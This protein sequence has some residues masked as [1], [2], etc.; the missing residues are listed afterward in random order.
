MFLFIAEYYEINGMAIPYRQIGF[1]TL[2]DFLR[3]HPDKFRISQIGG[4]FAISAVLENGG[5]ADL[6]RLV[7]GQKSSKKKKSKAASRPVYST[8]KKPSVYSAYTFKS[9][10]MTQSPSM[11]FNSKLNNHN[12]WWWQNIPFLVEII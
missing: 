5:M 1:D 8:Y 2:Q 12:S 7:Q 10:Q 4:D 3:T 6:A 11:Q 9:S